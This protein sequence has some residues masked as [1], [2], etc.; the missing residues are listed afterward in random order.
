[1]RVNDL[2]EPMQSAYKKMHST[3]TGLLKVQNDILC[4]IDNKKA[5]V[6]VLLDLSA[7][8][9][10]VDHDMLLHRMSTRLGVKGNVLSWFRSYLSNRQQHVCIQGVSSSTHKSFSV[11]CPRDQCLVHCCFLYIPCHSEI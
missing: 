4:A 7:A 11:V 8:F 10:T 3:E 2:D 6:L 5:V 9:D 1:M